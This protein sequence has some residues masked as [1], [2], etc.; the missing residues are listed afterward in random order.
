M[1]Y[2]AFTVGDF[3]WQ[4]ICSYE[5]W[6]RLSMPYKA[7]TVGDFLVLRGKDAANKGLSMPYKAFTVGDNA[8]AA[9]AKEVKTAYAF[10]AL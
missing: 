6:E 1:P 7:F 2:K 3:R 9:G 5:L 8:S 10:H 4:L